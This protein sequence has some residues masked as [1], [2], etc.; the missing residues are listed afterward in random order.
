M[1]PQKD[2]TDCKV[3]QSY[4]ATIS[5][6]ISSLHLQPHCIRENP[7]II[8]VLCEKEKSNQIVTR[9]KSELI[10]TSAYRWWGGCA[11]G[12]ISCQWRPTLCMALPPLKASGGGWK[13]QD[14]SEHIN[15]TLVCRDWCLE[16]TEAAVEQRKPDNEIKLSGVRKE[17]NKTKKMK[18]N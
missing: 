16:L 14:F 15:G 11:H 8:C 10:L 18:E 17:K 7:R 3:E 4:Q 12:H 2:K 9:T 6:A 13:G 1:E 5:P